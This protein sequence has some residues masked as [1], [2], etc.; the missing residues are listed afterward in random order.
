MPRVGRQVI[1]FG[2]VG[3]SVAVARRLGKLSRFYRRSFADG[4]WRSAT[5]ID[6]RFRGQVVSKNPVPDPPPG[7]AEA[8]DSIRPAAR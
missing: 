8:G 6:L 2:E 4:W 5:E 3:D 1:R 7:T